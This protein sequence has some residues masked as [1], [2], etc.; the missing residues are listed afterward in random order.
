MST[1][2]ELDAKFQGKTLPELWTAADAAA[3]ELA[4]A[5]F[6]LKGPK[7]DT[8]MSQ[9]GLFS[10]LMAWYLLRLKPGQR[11]TL[12]REAKKALEELRALP[13]PYEDFVID[14]YAA[15]S[16]EE[17]IVIKATLVPRRK[18]RGLA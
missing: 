14:R 1:P 16:R 18:Q 3:E 8:A 9:S 2:R 10:S 15:K 11:L 4:K 6:K 13:E 17:S 5:G 7:R 12:M